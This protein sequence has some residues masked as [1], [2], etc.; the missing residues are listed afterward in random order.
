[1]SRA[2]V[3][4]EVDW[5]VDGSAAE[6]IQEAIEISHNVDIL[7]D[8][9]EAGA[10]SR[11]EGAK[12]TREAKKRE[13]QLKE[14]LLDMA[15]AL[16][17]VEET[18]SLKELWDELDSKEQEGITEELEEKAEEMKGFWERRQGNHP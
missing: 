4:S 5:S 18:E 2:I 15:Q 11:A 6:L 14:Q 7:I 9:I 17:A 10:P 1:M 16:Q 8:E 3:T 12:G 13:K